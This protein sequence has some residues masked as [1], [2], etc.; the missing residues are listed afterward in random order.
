M[1]ACLWSIAAILTL[2]S[3][4][5]YAQVKPK[6]PVL[7]GPPGSG[8]LASAEKEIER[9][10]RHDHAKP[11]SALEVIAWRRSESRCADCDAIP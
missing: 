5:K 3:C 6:H 8:E 11:L 9:A 2:A 4:A 1:R 7:Q 10:L